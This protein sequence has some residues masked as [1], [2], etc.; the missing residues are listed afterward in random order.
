MRR[1]DFMKKSLIAVLLCLAVVMACLS[2]CAT[3]DE[4][5]YHNIKTDMNVYS[6]GTQSVTIE[7]STEHSDEPEVVFKSGISASDIELGEALEGKTVTKVTYVSVS[8]II[9]ELSGETKV[10]GGADVLGSITVKH[11]G[12]D[13]KGAS[14]CY[15]KV[16]APE[17]R[18][19][20]SMSNMRKNG[21]E[22]VYS[23]LTTFDL[24]VGEFTDAATVENI[25]LAGG[26]T[27]K[28]TVE[29]ADGKLTVRVDN[30]NVANPEVLFGANVTTIGKAVT[31]KLG[32]YTGAD[33]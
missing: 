13:S 31:V 18:V 23:I 27:G 19:T 12:L 2:A 8:S 22:T 16:L 33:F 9:V 4:E 11:S 30:C 28:L 14:V 3:G 21:D 20:A 29:L 5:R 15:L 26:V 6:M 7:K 17:L 24:P 10:H 32:T 25:T 1:R